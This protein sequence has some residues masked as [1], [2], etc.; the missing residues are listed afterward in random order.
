MRPLDVKPQKQPLITYHAR[1]SRKYQ[2]GELLTIEQVLSIIGERSLGRH[3]EPFAKRRAGQ[4]RRQERAFI[5]SR[6]CGFG[7]D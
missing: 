1:A 4:L 5:I 6:K 7:C 3:P 2:W